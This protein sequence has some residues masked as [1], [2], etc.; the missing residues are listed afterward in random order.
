MFLRNPD[1]IKSVTGEIVDPKTL[2]GSQVHI[3]MS[4]SG[5]A[6]MAAASFLKW[7][8]LQ[9]LLL[10][11]FAFV[12]DKVAGLLSGKLMCPLS[13]QKINPFIG[14]AGISAFPMAR[15]G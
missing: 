3:H 8:T 6:H 2:G 14:A 12:I 13:K 1:V 9:I 7:T 5:T 11:R 10:G 15:R 4:I